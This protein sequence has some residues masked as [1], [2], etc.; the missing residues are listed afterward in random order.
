VAALRPN[1]IIP[2]VAAIMVGLAFAAVIYG[3]FRFGRRLLVGSS[4]DTAT[5]QER[6][7]ELPANAERDGA[8]AAAS[9][10]VLYEL[11]QSAQG[12]RHDGSVS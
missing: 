5:V 2:L 12:Q 1:Q 10:A 4:T 9:P 11:D 3:G 8:G 7:N 6:L